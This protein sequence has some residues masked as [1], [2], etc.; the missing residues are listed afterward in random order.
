M[1][2]E[3]ENYGNFRGNVEGKDK[4]VKTLSFWGQTRFQVPGMG[5]RS[6]DNWMMKGHLLRW[7]HTLLSQAEMPRVHVFFM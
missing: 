1:T 4:S 7:K 3:R 5:D 2:K 6:T